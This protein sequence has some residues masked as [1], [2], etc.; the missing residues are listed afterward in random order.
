MLSLRTKLLIPTLLTALLALSGIV[1]I[2]ILQYNSF[3]EHNEGHAVERREHLHLLLGG[4]QEQTRD[5]T[6]LLSNKW[7]FLDSLSTGNIDFLLNELT[8]FHDGL[9][10][11][12]VAV[13]DLEGNAIARGDAPGDFGRSDELRE[14]ITKLKTGKKSTSIVTMYEG[15]LLLLNLKRLETGYRAI[16]VLAVGQ[17]LG[18]KLVDEFARSY[19]IYMALQYNDNTVVSSNDAQL[20]KNI[21]LKEFQ[22]QFENQF[23]PDTLLSAIVWEDISEI[24]SQFWHSLLLVIFIIAFA[25]GLVIYFSRR[26]VTKTV[27]TLDK[28]RTTAEEELAKRKLAEEALKQ[29]NQQ[30]E[31]RVE[32]RT[33][34]LE[35][36][37]TVRKQ[38]EGKLGK[39]EEK[40][41]SLTDDVLDS[42]AVGIFILDSDFRV[43]WVNQTT[44][45]YFGL[46][47][48]EIIG[49]DKRQ[50]IRERI[51]GIFEDPDS[52]TDKV[53]TAYDD[54]TYIE[55]FECHVL[56]N[57]KREERW[58]EHRSQPIQTGLYAGGKIEHY[59]DITDLKQAEEALRERESQ[60]R[61]IIDLVP[62]FIFVKDETG[63]FEIVNKATAEVFGTTVEDLTG[64]RDS[65][66]VATDEEMEHF[67]LDDLEVIR[68]GKTKFIP[69]EPI[70]DSENNI[71]YL[72]TTK[73]PFTTSGSE[74]PSLLGVAVDITRRVRAEEQFRESEMK[75]NG[76]GSFAFS[77]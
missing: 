24:K 38:I 6:E 32:E 77:I 5:L 11:D 31:E 53:F 15:K 27:D 75:L 35:D 66:F 9:G 13:Y 52:F 55:R 48:N 3:I 43:V 69:E 41:R 51:K 50:L 26:I 29:L 57:G 60:L 64:R 44:E 65:E 34:H 40:Y 49:K 22:V 54:N 20:P 28:A 63:K 73:V 33:K 12:F 23:G 2:S 74:K 7:D 62:H 8:P 19:Q 1:Y 45:V 61:Q 4:L 71:R 68:S 47:R 72:Q 59:Y 67:R 42:S 37:I 18:K 58:L 36:E 30:L 39:S 46:K 70:T 25:S 76:C 17:Y 21:D 10:Y 16:G 56:P 14:Y